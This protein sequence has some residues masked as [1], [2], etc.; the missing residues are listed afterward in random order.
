[1]RGGGGSTKSFSY[2]KNSTDPFV[3]ILV[4]LER[5]GSRRYFELLHIK[6]HGRSS[7]IFSIEVGRV[8]IFR[9]ICI[10]FYIFVRDMKHCF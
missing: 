9:A 8:T 1:M 4:T 3:M 2:Q 7:E 6:I 10:G 5:G